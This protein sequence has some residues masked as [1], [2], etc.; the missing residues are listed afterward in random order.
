MTQQQ[1]PTIIY[2]ATLNPDVCDVKEHAGEMLARVCHPNGSGQVISVGL[3]NDPR[4]LRD[5][6]I[7]WLSAHIAAAR[8]EFEAT[9]GLD[10]RHDDQ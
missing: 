5:T 7:R 3:R 4:L 1:I 10:D 8:K 2:R 6:L 9:A